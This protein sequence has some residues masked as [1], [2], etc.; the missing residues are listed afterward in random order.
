MSAITGEKEI[1]IGDKKFIVRF[2]WKALAEI[3]DK[4]GDTPNL[5]K[6]EVVAFVAS[7][8]LLARYPEMTPGKI[9]ELSPPFLPFA[10]DIQLALKWAY[11][12]GENVPEMD[13]TE[14][15]SIQK[16]GLL[17]RIRMLFVRA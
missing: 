14:K 4:Y 3:A 5:F 13:S 12:G 16:T 9:M 15:K 1:T 10:N 8:G 6:P 11:F 7:M 17:T 2:N